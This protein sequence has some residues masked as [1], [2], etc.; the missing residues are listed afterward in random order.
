MRNDTILV[1]VD[2]SGCAYEVVAAASDIAGRLGA[3]VVML[4]VVDLPAS[5]SS[6]AIVHPYGSDEAVRAGEYLDAD[7]RAHLEPLT[8][9]FLDAGCDVRIA[10]KH[11][12]PAQAILDT[13]AQVHASMIIMGT[14]GRTGVR[15]LVE[16]SVAEAVIR[17]ADCPVT[18]IRTQAPQEHPGMSDAQLQALDEALG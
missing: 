10:L 13:A 6:Q 17:K 15:R 1:P 18:T 3:D 2:Y 4:C 11:G 14:H 9:V 16:G 5:L 7:A 8:Q 12:S